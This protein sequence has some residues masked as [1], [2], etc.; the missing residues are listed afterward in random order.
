MSES[1]TEDDDIR[2]LN[3]QIDNWVCLEDC[4]E[5]DEVPS[6]HSVSG[7]SSRPLFVKLMVN[8]IRLRMELD[9]GAAYSIVMLV[10]KSYLA[11]GSTVLNVRK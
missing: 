7:S 8:K 9:N 4:P 5:E 11:V 2:F 6:L 10:V 1:V 3:E